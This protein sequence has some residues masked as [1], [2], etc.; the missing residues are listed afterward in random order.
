MGF[1]TIDGMKC[2]RVEAVVTG[3][4]KGTGEQMGAPLTIEGTSEGTETWYFAIEEGVYVKGTTKMATTATVTVSG[5][6]EMVIPM[7]M[8]MTV[9]TNLEK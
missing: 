4:M 8:D 7:T 3:T 5:P 1:E 2:A 6:Q 9:E